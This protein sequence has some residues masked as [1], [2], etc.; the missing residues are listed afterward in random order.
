MLLWAPWMALMVESLSA[1][2]RD[3]RDVGSIPGSETSPGEGNENSF[4]YSCLENSKDR[5]L[6]GYS[7]WSHKELDTTEQLTIRK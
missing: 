3:V 6:A 1:S 5:N 2:A 7:R 4:Q